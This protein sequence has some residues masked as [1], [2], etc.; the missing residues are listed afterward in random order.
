MG[1]QV[2]GIKLASPKSKNATWARRYNT[3]F[4]FSEAGQVS[5]RFPVPGD[6]GGVEGWRLPRGLLS[7]GVLRLRGGGDR[8]TKSAL[9]RSGGRPGGDAR[10][11]ARGSPGSP[12]TQAGCLPCNM[13][14]SFFLST[15]NRSSLHSGL[16]RGAPATR[17]SSEPGMGES[18]LRSLLEPGSD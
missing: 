16:C 2:S 8:G 17:S 1:A 9:G 18:V 7:L 3:A 10:E 14:S 15:R 12:R 6:L 5:T 4:G 13:A 11:G